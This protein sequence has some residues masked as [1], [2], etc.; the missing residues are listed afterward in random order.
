MPAAEGLKR[1]VEQARSDP[2]FFHDLVFNPEKAI[3]QAKYLD[4]RTKLTL[5][6][7]NADTLLR[8]LL[9]DK[10]AECGD[11]CGAGSCSSTCGGGSCLDTCKS[12]CGSTCGARSCDHTSGFV[13]TPEDTDPLTTPGG[14]VQTGGVKTPIGRGRARSRSRR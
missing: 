10:I 7:L 5:R 2:Q 9:P 6:R 11:T 12:S 8:N 3:T 13:Q 4:D 14:V 1:L